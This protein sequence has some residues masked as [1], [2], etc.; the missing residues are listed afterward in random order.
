MYTDGALPGANNG[1]DPAAF[2]ADLEK[3]R[4]PM[5][6]APAATNPPIPVGR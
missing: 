4:D 2:F 5:F 3:E 1:K 6:G